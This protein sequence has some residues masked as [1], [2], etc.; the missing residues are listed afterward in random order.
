MR[1]DFMDKEIGKIIFNESLV[2]DNHVFITVYKC[3]HIYPT[4]F[5]TF[6]SMPEATNDG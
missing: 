3:I 5:L 1:E 4:A 2:C 6:E